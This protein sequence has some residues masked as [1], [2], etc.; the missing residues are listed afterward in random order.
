MKM[1]NEKIPTKEHFD[2]LLECVR[3]TDESISLHT[4]KVY[5]EELEHIV[6]PEPDDPL[7]RE[8]IDN[9]WIK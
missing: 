6:F 5:L 9:G 8:W 7:V 1:L 2:R 3:T 4:I